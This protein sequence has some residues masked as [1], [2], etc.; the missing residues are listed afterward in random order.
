MVPMVDEAVKALEISIADII[1][2]P[3]EDGENMTELEGEQDG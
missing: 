3:D 1:Y 2:E